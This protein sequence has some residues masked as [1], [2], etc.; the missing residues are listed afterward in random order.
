MTDAGSRSIWISRSPFRGEG[1]GEGRPVPSFPYVG[2]DLT[3]G[4]RASDI[5]A[6]D[7][8]AQRL[9]LARAL[10]DDDLLAALAS[11]DASIVAI[12]S[13]MGLPAGLCCLEDSCG[14]TPHRQGTGRSAERE[15]AR[16]GISCFWTTKR[17]IVKAMI[18]RAMALKD[19][20]EEEGYI[21]LEVYPYAVKRLLLGRDL[22][23]KAGP[24]GLRRLVDGAGALLPARAWPAPWAPTHDQLDA[25]YC[26]ITA[27]L[28]ALGQTE[29]LG[30]IEEVPIV[31]PKSPLPG[32]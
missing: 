14:C 10:T 8:S 11:L 32:P 19:R 29:S 23:H 20:L 30:D 31:I 12:D 16:L 28:Y 17:T 6:L 25:L 21:V 3:A 15:L 1:W 26:A 4:R 5:A 18:Y 24:A 2:V 9:A 27:R 7:T 22:P 13:P